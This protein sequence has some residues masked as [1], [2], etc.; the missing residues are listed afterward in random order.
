MSSKF[1]VHLINM[2]QVVS[3]KFFQ[4]LPYEFYGKIMVIF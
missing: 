3:N 2:H 1:A 4:K